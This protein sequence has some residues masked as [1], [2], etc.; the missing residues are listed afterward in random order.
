MNH[1]CHIVLLFELSGGRHSDTENH[2]ETTRKL[3]VFIVSQLLCFIIKY[4][5]YLIKTNRPFS[6]NYHSYCIILRG[7]STVLGTNQRTS[8]S[9]QS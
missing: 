4:Q 9:I 5:R 1:H 7:N 3:K 2:T 6:L 8:T